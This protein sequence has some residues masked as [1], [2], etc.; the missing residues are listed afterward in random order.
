MR[1][2][3]A[4]PNRKSS[5][6]RS[7]TL[8]VALK[9]STSAFFPLDYLVPFPGLY[10]FLFG[11]Q[12]FEYAQL[13]ASRFLM[14]VSRLTANSVPVLSPFSKNESWLCHE[15]LINSV[16]PDVAVFTNIAL[17]LWIGGIRRVW[18]VVKR[19]RVANAASCLSLD[20][21]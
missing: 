5:L 3:V 4:S 10:Q 19:L 20:L 6:K 1:T 2:S 16:V 11:T 9:T 14:R 18:L 12:S 15:T 8:V 13:R 17:L 21:D 7:H